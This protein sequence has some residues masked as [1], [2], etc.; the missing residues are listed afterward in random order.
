MNAVQNFF[1]GCIRAETSGKKETASE[2]LKS[3]SLATIKRLDKVIVGPLGFSA[4]VERSK[5]MKQNVAELWY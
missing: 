3:S 5:H 1:D 2:T 4:L